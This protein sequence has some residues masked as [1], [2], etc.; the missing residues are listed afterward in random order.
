MTV[1]TA[2]RNLHIRN[3]LLVAYIGLL[4]PV[5]IIGGLGTM[6]LTRQTIQANIESDL[7]HVTRS[8]VNLVETTATAAIKTHLKAVAE[9]NLQI[10]RQIHRRALAGEISIERARARIRR[11]L[12]SQ[13][14][15]E[16]GY[17]YCIDSRGDAVVHPNPDVE[18]QD[19]SHFPFV[20]DQTRRKEGYFEYDWRNPG[21]AT[22]R[23]KAAYMVYFAPL[24][25]IIT[26]TTY[27]AEFKSLLPM[28][29]IRKSVLSFQ[30]GR[31]GYVFVAER[32]GQVL[33]HPVLE[34]VDIFTLPNM[35]TG[36]FERMQ[37]EKSG[38][39]T[40]TWQ[41]PGELRPR[42]KL[43]YFGSIAEFG[44]IVGST[45]YIDEI[46]AP[47][48][49]ARTLILAFMV[50][51][52]ILCVVLTLWISAR[53]TTPVET[54]M[55][56]VTRGRDGDYEARVS[57][58]GED[59][60]GRLGGMFN[61]F[62]TRL[63]TYHRDLV[64]EIEE[65]KRTEAYL[66][67]SRLKFQAIFN[68]T[69][70]MIGVL[71]PDGTV[72]EVNQT[73][74]N[75]LGLQT[76]AIVGRPFWETP[77][78][79]HD[80]GS[81]EQVREAVGKAARGEFNRFETTHVAPDGRR[82]HVDFSLKPVHDDHGRVIMLIPE[83]R[84]ITERKEAEDV[85]R[86]SEEKYRQV[87]ENAHDAI[88]V[89]QDRRL[90][91]ANRSAETFLGYDRQ[92][93]ARMTFDRLIHSDDRSLVVS[94]HLKRIAGE[95]APNDFSVRLVARGGRVKW[96]EVNA[97]R[98]D[99]ENRP[100]VIAFLRDIT[101]QK[102]LESQLLQSQKMEAI[103]TLAGG[104]AHDFNN[105]L[106][107]VSGY[108]QLLLMDPAKSAKDKE[109]L[110]TIQQAASHA[111][112]LTRQLL[113]F[114][115]KIESNPVPLNLNAEIALTC[116]L[117]ERTLPKMIRIETRL[118]ED[119][120][121]VRVDKVQLEQVL[122]NLG[123]N[124]GHAMPDGGRLIFATASV[125]LTE[126]FCR[127]HLD[128]RTGRHVELTV[129]DDGVGMD[130]KIRQHIF[131]PFFTTRETGAGTGLGLAMV[132]GI[133]TSHGGVITCESTPG[134]GTTFRLYFPVAELALADQEAAMP[135]VEKVGGSETVLVVDDDPVVRRLGCSLLERFGYTVLEAA[136]GEEALEIYERNGSSI[137]L[138]ILD[139][140]MPGM[141]GGSCLAR[142]MEMDPAARVIIASGYAPQGTEAESLAQ[143]AR[144]FLGKPYQLDGMLQMVREV[145]D[146][147]A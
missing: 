103:G 102:Q 75:F 52:V 87:V 98:I 104:I 82:R 76:G 110:A 47:V 133:V 30:F 49:R 127:S 89:V 86:I 100:A 79:A 46:Y 142:L 38:R 11:Q 93:L 85:L 28:A 134:Q 16:T 21:E 43:V 70:Q 61:A 13:V 95:D 146:Q 113:T 29:D 108:T 64:T 51:A 14:I 59:E 33:V 62:M 63:Q 40:Y 65:R 130:E 18:G 117:L 112:G 94:R 34:D 145:L 92:A 25:W 53:I 124:A 60:I 71:D 122:M 35:D 143:Q 37:Q 67:E 24:D 121:I 115:R 129:T 80:A 84:D 99:W 139:L 141:G 90:R 137:A 27:R 97:V 1:S 78:W 55:A 12:L 105:S 9:Q 72:Q 8:I 131:E 44:W 111:E 138:T 3:K 140:N 144:G 2:F 128:L 107:A 73:A 88:L 20:Y 41:N 45:G 132:Y 116:R 32:S 56:A 109:M 7:Q 119:L 68:Q 69:F 42:E 48:E 74:L 120:P 22:A 50:A 126:G 135:E 4:I 57:D 23:P 96:V 81:R 91:F 39:L 54:L 19:F 17:I 36:F 10:A 26:V 77:F 31:S 101:S 118:A 136:S 106:Q 125:L 147:T 114:S 6:H 5:I 83:G 123:I 15:G 58:L 66:Q